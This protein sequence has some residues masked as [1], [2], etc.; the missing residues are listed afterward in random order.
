MTARPRLAL[1]NAAY[2]ASRPRRNFQ[3]VLDAD[4][5][6]FHVAGGHY[7]P[8][9]E[10]LEVDGVVVS[11]SPASVYDDAAWI[12]RTKA[13]VGEAI[14]TGL[15]HLGVCFGHQLLADVLGGTVEPME[16]YELGYRTVRHHGGRLFDGVDERFL[17][18]TTHKDAVTALPPGASLTAENDYGVHGFRLDH[19]HG[20]QFHPE[21]DRATAARITRQKDLPPWRISRVLDDVTQRN[22]RRAK[23]A[24]RVLVN[25]VGYVEEVRRGGVSEGHPP[26]ATTR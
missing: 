2:N 13:W 4:I 7:P 8:A 5:V 14:V 23:E 1:L 9:P 10:R 12:G 26:R 11:G 21:Y 15:P 24:T 20:I 16:E 22:V 25:F 6:E 17:V 19:V 3:R 18:F